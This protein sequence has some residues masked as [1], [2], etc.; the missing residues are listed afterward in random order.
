[1]YIYYAN[2][3]IYIHIHNIYIY[4]YIYM[5]VCMYVYMSIQSIHI[6]L[7]CCLVG[8]IR[9]RRT[10]DEKHIAYHKIYLLR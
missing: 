9:T 2:I 5:Y 6:H 4:I 1:M 7:S 3:C 10:Y 8:S